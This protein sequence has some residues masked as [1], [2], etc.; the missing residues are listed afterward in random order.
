LTFCIAG[1]EDFSGFNSGNQPTTFSGGTIDTAYGP[2]GGVRIEGVTVSSGGW[3]MGTH[4]LL[5]GASVNSFR[6][7]FTKA[8]GSVHL[9]AVDG[10]GNLTLTGY[11]AANAVV[12]SDT[13]PSSA[14][15]PPN[16]VSLSIS[17]AANTI[18]SFTIATS[19]VTAV[20]FTN[21]VWTCN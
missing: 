8:V 10:S 16:A 11:D 7:T 3:V 21:I 20:A 4:L 15:P 9:E 1:S 12:A 5:S 18:K 17:S 13:E 19:Q 6:L 2:G 14:G